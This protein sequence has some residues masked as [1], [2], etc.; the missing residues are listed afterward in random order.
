MSTR[1]ITPPTVEPVDIEEMKLHLRVRDGADDTLIK[2]QMIAARE[3]CEEHLRRT[4]VETE[5]EYY[6]D[7][8]PSSEILLPMPNLLSVSEVAFQD[9]ATGIYDTSLVE[10]T[11]FEVDTIS[12]PGVVFPSYGLSWPS[13]RLTRNSVRITYKSGYG[14]T[15]GSVPGAIRAAIRLLVSNLYENREPTAM[16]AIVQ[17]V[18]FTVKA[19]LGPYRL[20]RVG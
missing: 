8:F 5:R 17:A 3:Y 18:P 2:A 6:S 9:P 14:S 12:V 4:L 13:A 1:V 11:D 15:A 7:R 20:P 19:L 16:T 10:G